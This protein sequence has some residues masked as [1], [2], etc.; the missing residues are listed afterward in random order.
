MRYAEAKSEVTTDITYRSVINKT[1]IANNNSD[2]VINA[3]LDAQA[4][5]IEE[6][7]ESTFHPTP[8]A[9]PRTFYAASSKT[10]FI[11]A[12]YELASVVDSDGQSVD[13]QQTT[14]RG[15]IYKLKGAFC[16][17]AQYVVTAKWGSET[18]PTAVKLANIELAAIWR[19][20]SPR[21]SGTLGIDTE[22]VVSEEALRILNRL[23]KTHRI[24]YPFGHRLMR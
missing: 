18:I 22:E 3:A 21:A 24:P 7:T 9:T 1:N 12:A 11:D 5:V 4:D 19:F 23:L 6:Y 20:E 10:M 8:V 2:A 15:Q 13:V 16:K 14:H 17:G